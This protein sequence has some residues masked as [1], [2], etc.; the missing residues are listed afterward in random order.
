MADVQVV[1]QQRNW[2]GFTV[3]DRKVARVSDQGVVEIWMLNEELLDLWHNGPDNES[4][5]IACILMQLK[6]LQKRV[7]GDNHLLIAEDVRGLFGKLHRG[8]GITEINTVAP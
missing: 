4:K 1:Q 7:Y 8:H 5:F 3:G 6:T 2:V